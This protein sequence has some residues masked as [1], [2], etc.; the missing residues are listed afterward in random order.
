MSEERHFIMK[1]PEL[2][3]G[4]ECEPLKEN[5]KIYDWWMDHLPIK[6]VQSHA[7][8]TGCV[9]Y[10]LNV[11]LPETAPVIP[12]DQVAYTQ[13]I[14]APD[15]V[16]HLSFNESGG[17]SGGRIGG[18]AGVY[19]PQT[20]DMPCAYCFQVIPEDLD[21]WKEAGKRIW[22]A[23]YKTKEIITVELTLKQ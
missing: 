3:L 12:K 18:I 7:V 1:W 15:G 9:F 6:A 19:G 21:K 14:D 23:V 20:E 8:V 13:M 5:R 2:D 16:G 17:L 10:T 11:R 22:N 4:V